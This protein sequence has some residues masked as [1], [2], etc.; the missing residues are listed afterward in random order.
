MNPRARAR[1]ELRASRR[2]LAQG[3]RWL[4]RAFG[5]LADWRAG[6][7]DPRVP[8][9]RY[10]LPSFLAQVL[11]RTVEHVILGAGGLREGE[12]VLDIGCGPGQI[13]IRV[14]PHLG[15]GLYEGFDVSPR[16]IEWCRKRIAP[17]D[18]R[19][20]FTLVDVGNGLYNPSGATDATELTFPYP[21][22]SFDLAFAGSVFTHLEPRESLHYLEE[23]SRVLRPGGRIVA[24]WYLVNEESTGLLDA[25]AGQV[26]LGSSSPMRLDHELTD[27][28]GWS[29]WT[30]HPRIPEQLIA[31]AEE[32]VMEFHARAG[33]GVTEVRW[34]HWCGRPQDPGRLGQDLVVAEAG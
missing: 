8:P 27:R 18:R 34:G 24:T 12:R 29:M 19:L 17:T 6:E 28:D 21:D 7:R 9:R 11:D 15:D 31:V 30:S 10:G 1:N 23:V 32:D 13:A 20:G 26:P 2:R 33:L 5:D 25:G 14:A 16:S 3:E 4:R 22:D